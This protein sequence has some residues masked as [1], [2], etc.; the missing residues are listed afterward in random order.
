M[1]A[2]DI[3]TLID[4]YI[5]QDP[6]KAFHNLN[7]NTVLHLLNRAAQGVAADPTAGGTMQEVD[8]SDFTAAT[9]CPLAPAFIGQ[10]IAV[11]YNEIGRYLLKGKLSGDPNEVDIDPAGGFTVNLPGFDASQGNHHFVASIVI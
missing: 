1:T 2:A 5:R 6:V 11:F 4:Q 3:D 9:Y 10:N 8:S 7:L